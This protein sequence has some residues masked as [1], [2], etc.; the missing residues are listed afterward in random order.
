VIRKA[1]PTLS[2][3]ALLASAAHAGTVY[4]PLPGNLTV[5][6]AAWEQVVFVS[7][8]GAQNAS[9]SELALRG[10]TDGTVRPPSPTSQALPAKQGTGLALDA[11]S[12]G[13][14]ELAG[15]DDLTFS[16]R[17]ERVDSEDS[18]ELPIISSA[19]AAAAGSTLYLQGL[20]RSAT[21][22]TD[23][24]LVNLGW[25]A[26]NCKVATFSV[27]G[28]P[29]GSP[30]TIILKPLSSKAF[31]DVL[32]TIGL[33]EAEYVRGS[34]SCD[35]QFYTFAMA[36]DTAS[37]DVGLIAPSGRGNSTLTLGG[38]GGNNPGNGPCP[39]G[40]SCFEVKGLAFKPSKQEPVHR[41]EFPV[42][43]G[44]YERIHFEMDVKH[45]GWDLARRSGKHMLFWLVKNRNYYMYG[46]ANF[47]GP[48]KN[49]VIFRHGVAITHPEKIKITAPMVAQEGHV[50]HLDYTYDTRQ[51]FL[52]LV[53]SE[54]GTALATIDG[55]PNTNVIDFA[56]GDVGII[57]IGF[58][59]SN[60]AERPTYGWEYRDIKIQWIK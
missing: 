41:F 33:S 19:N 6:S 21:V 42:P 17:L 14:L 38:D 47:E 30:A 54:N 13:L 12:Q 26:A 23:W 36:H 8:G 60:P 3:L 25:T 46:Y 57:D 31:P 39:A 16:A 52:K 49:D 44:N 24:T 29:I 32:Q 34:V 2:L 56:A 53:V 22:A 7:N 48:T 20:R 45:G 58:N 59:G 9:F 51:N 27:T 1:A 10:D 15:P 11:A 4:V 43:P 35:Q 40:A 37:G 18:T 55:T 5:G 28:S 50:Y